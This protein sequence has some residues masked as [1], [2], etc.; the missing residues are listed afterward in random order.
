MG[1]NVV[2]PMVTE[3]WMRSAAAG[4]RVDEG[5]A[6][7]TL[8]DDELGDYR[9]AHPLSLAIPLLEDVLGEAAR[10]SDA[11]MAVSDEHGQ[12]LWLCGT[13]DT[14]RRAEG[15]GFVEGSSWDER[16]AGTNAPGT[17]LALDRP[18]QVIRAEHFRSSVQSWSCAAAPIHDLSSGALLGIL[19]VTGGDQIVVPQTMAMLRAAARLAEIELARPDLEHPRLV[20]PGGSGGPRLEASGLG[21]ASAEVH[22]GGRGHRLGPRHSEM[23][24]L[25]AEAPDGLSGDEM[26]CGLYESGTA[27]STVRAETIRLKRVLGEDVLRSRPYRLHADLV[28]DW[29]AIEARLAVGDVIGAVRAYR[30]PLLPHSDAP[31]VVK[32]R[33]RVHLA[34][35]NAVVSSGRADL[36]S[37]WTRSVWGADD[38]TAWEALNAA[39]PVASPMRRLAQAQ[40]D[41]I[42]TELG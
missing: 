9:A 28:T 11:L 19:D 22:I 37:T 5:E 13:P 24:V 21:R 12:L 26:A 29:T 3:S 33:D 17:A 35:A 10:A 18:V 34:L 23:I 14:L 20:L 8:P 4:V 36:L 6:P 41:R 42:D 25:L 38:L 31:G 40:V 16:V 7:I 15:I 39:L 30:G 1:H 27:N 32:V 2:R